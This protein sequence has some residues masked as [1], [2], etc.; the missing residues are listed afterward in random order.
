MHL[1]RRILGC[2][3]LLASACMG[4]S[5]DA[6]FISGTLGF[7]ADSITAN[8]G[9]VNTATSFTFSTVNGGSNTQN[10]VGNG[11]GSFAAV[12]ANTVINSTPLQLSGPPFLTLTLG[13]SQFVAST[14][15][16]DANIPGSDFRTIVL[17][18]LITGVGFDPTSARFILQFNQAGGP[19]TTI[20]YSGTV[21]A[22]PVPE[23]SSVALI[24]C[25]LAAPALALARRR[26]TA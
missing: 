21:V 17:G 22:N 19:G 10:A 13:T 1:R 6:A 24:A 20:S 3:V 16:T 5:A 15:I 25:G 2:F 12:P 11:T 8:T 4:T 14:L 26:R 23:P 9:G 18:G 7:N